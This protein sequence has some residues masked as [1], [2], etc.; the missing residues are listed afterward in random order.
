M[1]YHVT[2]PDDRSLSYTE[3]QTALAALTEQS[4]RHA[5][6]ARLITGIGSIYV[7]EGG[8]LKLIHG[9]PDPTLEEAA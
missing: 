3:P 1:P 2:L 6:G 5:T 4:G 7:L 8:R 9:N